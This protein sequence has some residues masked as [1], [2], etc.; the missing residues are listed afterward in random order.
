MIKQIVPAAALATALAAG[1]IASAGTA[2]ATTSY[3]YH[4]DTHTYLLEP[5]SPYIVSK[6]HTF[7]LTIGPASKIIQM[8]WSTWRR[9]SASGTGTLYIGGAH[10]TRIGHATVHFYRDRH[11]KMQARYYTRLTLTAPGQHRTWKWSWTW[12]EWVWA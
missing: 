7:Y 12:N 3:R 2:S 8:R 1:T 5:D 6:P 11:L 9:T 10:W 4:G